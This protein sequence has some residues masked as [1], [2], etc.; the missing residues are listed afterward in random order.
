MRTTDGGKIHLP[1]FRGSH[2]DTVVALA[3][4]A[5]ELKDGSEARLLVPDGRVDV[6]AARGRIDRAAG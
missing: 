4:A 6:R 5:W 1:K 3:S 2:C